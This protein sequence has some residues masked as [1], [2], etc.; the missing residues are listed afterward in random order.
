MAGKQHLAL[1]SFHNGLNT[2]T[3]AR[4]IAPDELALLQNASVDDVK[5]LFRNFYHPSNAS[6]SIVGDVEPQSVFKL[7][8]KYFGDIEPGPS[9]E[10]LSTQTSTLRGETNLILEDNIQL[11]RLYLAWPVPEDFTREQAA[12]DILSVILA[13]GRSSRLERKLLYENQTAHDIRV[14]NHAQEISG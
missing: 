3:D 1:S 11:P 13:D 9:I 12:L 5:E 4:D 14:F 6:L 7:V 10:R 8:E 2:K